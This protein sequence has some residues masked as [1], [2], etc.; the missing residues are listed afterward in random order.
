MG[1]VF[2]AYDLL[3]NRAVA[4]KI[5]AGGN[6]D[7]AE[8]LRREAQVIASFQHPN[9]CDVYDV[10]VMPNGSPYLVLE[11]LTGETLHTSL[12]RQGR[13]PIAKT[14][15]LFTQMLS[16]A[17]HAH[18]SGIVHRD[19]KPANVFLVER[20]GLLPLVKLVDF[21]LAKDLS[22]KARNLTRPGKTCG[23]PH[24]MSPEQLCARPVD[25]RSDLFSIGIMLF[26]CLMN[27]H[28]FA[29]DTIVEITMKIAYE[30]SPELPRLRR[31]VVP[32]LAAIVERSLHKDP[33][34]RFQSAVEFQTALAGVELPEDDDETLSDSQSLPSIMIHDS[35]TS[36]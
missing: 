25:A 28:P 30:E 3:L 32:E 14:V 2:E 24:Y 8:R 6:P 35:G 19:L 1:E 33:A 23:T 17:Q 7:A 27:R 31:K 11:R 13:L 29:A 20:L 10:G 36:S 4:I 5:V 12:R 15:E 21:G 26:E 9:I 22:G 18:A 34:R 16:G